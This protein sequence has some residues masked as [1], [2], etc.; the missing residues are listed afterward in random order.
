VGGAGGADRRQAVAAGRKSGT[1]SD[2]PPQSTD[3]V[4]EDKPAHADLPSIRVIGFPGRFTAWGLDLVR[5]VLELAGLAIEIIP[6]AQAPALGK[7]PVGEPGA[8]VRVLL[9][10]GPML[11]HADILPDAG[12]RT[13]VFLDDP[14]HALD[15][16]VG[17][18]GEPRDAAR[19]LTATLAPLA[20]V[21]REPGVLLV[22]RIAGM[23][24]MAALQAIA[25]HLV[26]TLPPVVTVAN[27]S[28]PDIAE[29][30][31]EPSDTVRDL[32]GQV[33]TPLINLAIGGA[34]EPMVYPLHCFYRGDRA[35]EPALPIVDLL[36]PRR[37]LY[38][39]PAFYVPPGR[40]RVDAELYFSDDAHNAKCALDVLAGVERVTGLELVELVTVQIRPQEGGLF[41]ASFPVTIERPDDRIEIRVWLDRGA[42][43]GQIGLRQITLHPDEADDS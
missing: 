17:G 32:T 2:D 6:L 37:V 11:G 5:Q 39:G 22:R 9:A 19:V 27:D 36:G 25:A 34:R 3:A 12:S 21:L 38:H 15:E 7:V 41:L 35:F 28:T 29:T 23:D 20:P 42:I 4:A 13:I 24:P 1:V 33:L 26:P 8:V 14:M 30:A 31:R 10:H 16:L 43:E 18:A 40:W